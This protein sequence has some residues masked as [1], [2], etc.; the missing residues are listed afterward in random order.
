MEGARAGCTQPSSISILRAWQGTGQ[1]PPGRAS[2]TLSRSACGSRGRL[3]W[4]HMNR[5]EFEDRECIHSRKYRIAKDAGILQ[6]L[7]RWL[8]P[9]VPKAIRHA[10]SWP[11]HFRGEGPAIE[12]VD[13]S[14]YGGSGGT[15][16]V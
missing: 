3:R 11:P 10:S 9:A 2:G 1:P 14:A 4:E 15:E 12:M 8:I 7:E 13:V 6:Q 5:C 16:K